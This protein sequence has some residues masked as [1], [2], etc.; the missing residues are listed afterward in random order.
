VRF[1]DVGS[2]TQVRQVAASEF[3]F[4]ESPSNEDKTNRHVLTT[5]G[6]EL[7]LITAL[8]PSGGEQQGAAAPVACFKAPHPIMVVRRHRATICVGCDGGEVLFL[9]APF[10]AA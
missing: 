1:W 9:R 2:G 5:D 8:P 7:L 6:A 3:A 10:L 4:A